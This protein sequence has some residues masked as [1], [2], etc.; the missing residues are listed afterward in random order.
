MADAEFRIDGLDELTEQL[1]ALTETLNSRLERAGQKIAQR[2]E[3]DAKEEVPVDKGELRASIR[4]AVDAVGR[5]L[6]EVRV[7]SS[8]E[9]AAAQEFG[10]DPFFPPVSA[11]RDWARRVL[12]DESAA[13][14]VAKSISETG[15]DA[16]PFLR[17]AFE[18]NIQF[19]LNTVNDAVT[20]AFADVGFDV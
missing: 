18:E 9:Y 7:G 6:V 16:Q 15:L 2:I 3:R 1:R 13:F 10:A 20:E 4:S 5:G 14:P 11:L 17:P 12:G 19:M 8:Q